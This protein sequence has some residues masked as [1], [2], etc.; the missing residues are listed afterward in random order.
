MSRSDYS[1]QL[2]VLGALYKCGGIIYI[3]INGAGQSL[4]RHKVL[5]AVVAELGIYK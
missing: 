5:N 4:P 3:Y 1:A 2:G